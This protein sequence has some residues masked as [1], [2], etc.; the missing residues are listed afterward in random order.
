M[1]K[2]LYKSKIADKREDIVAL[3]A[4]I[5]RVKDEKKDGWNL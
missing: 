2:E 1:S 4:K 3:R 5:V